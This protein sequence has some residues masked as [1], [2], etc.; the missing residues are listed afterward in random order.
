M[1]YWGVWKLYFQLP[2]FSR[3]YSGCAFFALEKMITDADQNLACSW[4]WARTGRKEL[5]QLVMN[6]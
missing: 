5:L 2:A 1:A 4:H 3:R 6:V